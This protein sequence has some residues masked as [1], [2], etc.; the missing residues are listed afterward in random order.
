M[1]RF[2]RSLAWMFLV[3]ITSPA[4]AQDVIVFSSNRPFPASGGWEMSLYRMNV[5]RTGLPDPTTL[6]DLT[7][8]W[9]VTPQPEWAPAV[10]PDGNWIAVVADGSL[11]RM[12][13]DNPIPPFFV[14]GDA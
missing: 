10:S 5:D 2:S 8:G 6:R 9:P 7:P 13:L 3:G 14:T 12:R 11:W 4:L 1:H